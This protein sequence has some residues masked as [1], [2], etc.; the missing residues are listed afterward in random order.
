M[1]E[2]TVMTYN[3]QFNLD[4]WR[5]ARKAKTIEVL[6]FYRPDI[7]ACQECTS[8]H[9][10]DLMD[11]LMAGDDYRLS[12]V[13]PAPGRNNKPGLMNPIFF[14]R[15]AFRLLS[16]GHVDLPTSSSPSHVHWAKLRHRHSNRTLVVY[17]MHLDQALGPKRKSWA[18]VDG[19]IRQNITHE[20]IMIGDLNMHENE[21]I[22]RNIIE[23]PDSSPVR[24]DDGQKL[25]FAVR[26]SYMEAEHVDA[27]FLVTCL[28]GEKTMA[29]LKAR[30]NR[31]GRIDHIWYVG[32]PNRVLEPV[33]YRILINKVTRVASD[34]FPVQCTFT[35]EDDFSDFETQPAPWLVPKK[36]KK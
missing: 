20:H 21:A 2:F 28:K 27:M 8:E 14:N 25:H 9:E 31:A 26:D 6:K 4:S 5:T 17:N 12:S 36:R 13:T 22:Y 35:L 1:Q 30:A 24:T 34:H 3:V 23:R 32:R 33:K 7:L 19:L 11:A 16:D 18:I 29:K 15:K 10:R